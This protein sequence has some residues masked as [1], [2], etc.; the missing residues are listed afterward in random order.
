MDEAKRL[1]SLIRFYAD[2]WE[3][4]AMVS[5]S[6]LATQSI[7][8]DAPSDREVAQRVRALGVMLKTSSR[9]D[10]LLRA[11]QQREQ[12]VREGARK[13]PALPDLKPGD[14]PARD[15]WPEQPQGPGPAL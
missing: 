9:V 4:D 6:E 8:A 12:E 13:P 1:E 5:L 2:K 3:T 11:H 15:F 10:R 7:K 14:V